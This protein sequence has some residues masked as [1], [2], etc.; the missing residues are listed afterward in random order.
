MLFSIIVDHFLLVKCARR[1]VYIISI[2]NGG[3]FFIGSIV[4][5]FFFHSRSSLKAVC[6]NLEVILL[7]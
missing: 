7:Q 1:H 4:F 3:F 6:Q 2:M 5:V